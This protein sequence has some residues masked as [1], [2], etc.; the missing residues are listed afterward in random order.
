MPQDMTEFDAALKEDFLPGIRKQFSE[1]AGLEEFT[2]KNSEDVEGQYARLALHVAASGGIGSRGATGATLP[3][4]GNQELAEQQVLMRYHYGR[5][6]VELPVIE[7]SR[8]NKGSVVR[9]LDFEIRSIV[10]NLKRDLNRQRFGTSD[11]VIANTKDEASS[12]TVTLAVATTQT[13]MR[14]LHVGMIIDI[15]TVAAPTGVASARTITAVNATAKTITISGAAVDC[16]DTDRIF[17][18][19]NGGSGSSQKELTGLQTIVDS[20]GTLF[21]VNPSTYPSWAA[22]EMGNSSVNRT[23]TEALFGEALNT[24]EIESGASPDLAVVGFGVHRAFAAQLLAEK[25]FVNT[26]DLKGGYTGLEIA[27]GGASVM[28][29]R[30]RDCPE[31]KAFLLSTDH[32]IDFVQSDYDWMDDDG[33][34][35]SRVSGEPAYEAVL[36]RYLEQATDQRNAHARIDDLTQ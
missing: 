2:R 1:K 11:G 9:A 31:N 36:Y 33:A 26:T 34:V 5:I 29:V 15:G 23:A 17:R 16:A 28:L 7:A 18:S 22:T 8:T 14:Q 10:P 3:T 12:T 21:N 13:Q 24:V 25:R 6:K 32:L 19:G 27:A 30:D 4:A 20:S 35:L